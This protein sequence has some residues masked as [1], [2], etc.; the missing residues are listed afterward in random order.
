MT[1]SMTRYDRRR[2]LDVIIIYRLYLL[3]S[4][5]HTAPVYCTVFSLSLSPTVILTDS[6]VSFSFFRAVSVS[7]IV[8]FILSVTSIGVLFSYNYYDLL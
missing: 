3:T 8:W 4:A 1:T 6:G 5:T 7:I 2:D